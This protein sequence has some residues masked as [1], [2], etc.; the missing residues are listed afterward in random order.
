MNIVQFFT[1]SSKKIKIFL[2]ILIA[3]L[4]LKLHLLALGGIG[5]NQV[6]QAKQEKGYKQF[7]ERE[8]RLSIPPLSEEEV[9]K[10][11]KKK[12]TVDVYGKTWREIKTEK[13][14]KLGKAIKPV[15]RKKPLQVKVEQCRRCK[16]PRE[17]LGLY[18]KHY[19]Q[20]SKQ[21]YQK[22]ICNICGLQY[23][24]ELSLLIQKRKI[25]HHRL[26]CPFCYEPIEIKK[27]RKSGF[28][29]YKCTN[30]NCSFKNNQELNPKGYR[31]TFRKYQWQASDLVLI[32]PVKDENLIDF[33]QIRTPLEIVEKTLTI[34]LSAGLS[35]RETERL[36]KELFNVK[37]SY[38]AIRQWETALAYL[39]FPLYEQ[40]VKLPLS[41]INVFDETYVKY[42][43][44][45][46]Y[47]F[48]AKD[49][50]YK[51]VTAL[52]FS[53]KRDAKA[54][55]VIACEVNRKLGEQGIREYI[56][57]RDKAP[58]YNVAFDWIRQNCQVKIKDIKLKGIFSQPEELEEEKPFRIFKQAIER[59]FSTYK[60]AYKRKKGFGSTN[61]VVTY[62]FLHLLYYNHLRPNEAI[63]NKQ[64]APLYFKDGR[65]VESWAGLIKF[66]TPT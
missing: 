1:L 27:H 38:E 54:A 2:L 56:N 33:R 53:T 63:G 34:R 29:I 46:G 4:S 61:G 11:R 39:L 37:V 45:W 14:F 30:L 60:L 66:L 5:I 6:S 13:E 57:V 7:T 16:A 15:N 19:D 65:K 28:D 9:G 10:Q 59:Y 25:S 49:A 48:A 40:K 12:R 32:R 31:Y 20:E 8:Y 36:L 47:L 21:S 42:Q 44:K 22:I 51:V 50:I 23:V 64:P 43:G 18:G 17:Y 58:I 41:G 3:S 35:L 26:Y 24:P 62:S 55:T 52:H